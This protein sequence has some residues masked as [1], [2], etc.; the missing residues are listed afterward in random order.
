MTGFDPVSSG[1][2]SNRAVNCATT[3]ALIFNI[4]GST[5]NFCCLPLDKEDEVCTSKYA[6]RFAIY[7]S[8]AVCQDWRI[9]KGLGDKFSCKSSPK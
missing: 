9:L 2:G 5:S 3:T 8:R 7:R 6:D 4:F 1:I